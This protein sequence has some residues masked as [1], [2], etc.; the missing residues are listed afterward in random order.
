MKTW[1]ISGLL[2]RQ[3]VIQ[4]V[5]KF[6]NVS[7][8]CLCDAL[9][10]GRRR[11]QSYD[12]QLIIKNAAGTLRAD[13]VSE[14]H[15]P[16][17]CRR[18]ERATT[19]CRVFGAFT[20]R[21]DAVGLSW[22]SPLWAL[23]FP[24]CLALCV[25]PS[26]AT[27]SAS[28]ISSRAEMN[29]H[30]PPASLRPSPSLILTFTPHNHPPQTEVSMNCSHSQV[31]GLQ[32]YNNISIFW[33]FLFS[34]L[35]NK[36][37]ICFKKYDTQQTTHRQRRRVTQRKQSRWSEKHSAHSTQTYKLNQSSVDLEM[38]E[39][40]ANELHFE[41]VFNATCFQPISVKRTNQSEAETRGSV[42]TVHIKSEQ[43]KPKSIWREIHLKPDVLSVLQTNR[44]RKAQEQ[45]VNS[46]VRN[47]KIKESPVLLFK[48][49]IYKIKAWNSTLLHR[50]FKN[51]Q[52]E[53]INKYPHHPPDSTN[54]DSVDWT[55]SGPFKASRS[56]LTALHLSLSR[57]P[58]LQMMSAWQVAAGAAKH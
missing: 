28:H 23:S 52:L 6:L 57:R 11:G 21:Q 53:K 19:V 3:R 12:Q 40:A 8:L 55:E 54:M 20:L 32:R 13:I 51:D 38:T 47:K 27:W 18:T 48:V 42:E 2:Q 56:V 10:S 17:H 16:R 44:E 49:D 30:A 22:A 37:T 15:V 1:K 7:L 39:T 5:D 43:Q 24:A 41:M 45:L 26:L 9:S 14:P 25:W 36:V 50:V 4:S 34:A 35:E 58:R 33:V 31:S 46:R 29:Q